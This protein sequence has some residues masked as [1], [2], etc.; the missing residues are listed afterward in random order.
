MQEEVNE[1][2][3]SLCIKGGKITAQILKAALITVSYERII[4]LY[5][6]RHVRTNLILANRNLY[7][8]IVVHAFIISIQ[9]SQETTPLYQ[10]LSLLSSCCHHTN[11]TIQR[12]WKQ[13]WYGSCIIFNMGRYN[14]FSCICDRE[15]YYVNSIWFSLISFNQ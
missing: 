8:F 9:E 12:K 14:T 10:Y 3:I 11:I 1:K 2:T 4:Q 13:R 15:Y 6:T 7:G 5:R